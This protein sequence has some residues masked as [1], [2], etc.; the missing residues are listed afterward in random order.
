MTIDFQQTG[1]TVS[2]HER[3]MQYK[4]LLQDTVFR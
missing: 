4:K 1:Q 3:S 2:V